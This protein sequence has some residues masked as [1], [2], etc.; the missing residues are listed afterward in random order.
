[1]KKISISHISVFFAIISFLFYS[2]NK[3]DNPVKSNEHYQFDSAR[4]NWNSIVLPYNW[5][6]YLP[7]WAPDTNEA[8]LSNSL[9]NNITH[10]K[11]GQIEIINFEN[12]III[13]SIAGFSPNEGYLICVEY[14]DSIWQPHIK[15]WN[16]NS[17]E[18]VPINH[19]FKK[20]FTVSTV[21]IKS[22][23]EMWFSGKGVIHKFDGYNLK[24]YYLADTNMWGTGIFYDEN[25][26]LKYLTTFYNEAIDSIQKDYVYEFDGSNWNKIYEDNTY[27]ITTKYYRVLGN[28]I[29]AYNGRQ[30]MKLEGNNLIIYMNISADMGFTLPFFGSSLNDFMAFGDSWDRKTNLFHWD[31]KKWSNEGKYEPF[32]KISGTKINDNSYCLTM[33]EY[34]VLAPLLIIGSKKSIEKSNLK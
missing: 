6:Y 34:N 1:M 32:A 21:L 8:F 12:N 22:S 18:V 19:N 33:C 28:T 2:C 26:H 7:P 5:G 11:N 15:R 30:I 29:F 13:G 4:F 27:P 20:N 16:G 31:G 25:N 23:N 24:Q 17:F 10:Y 9:L 3:D 14:K